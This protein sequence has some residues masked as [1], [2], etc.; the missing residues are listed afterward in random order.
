M[1]PRIGGEGR[2]PG[3]SAEIRSNQPKGPARS[4]VHRVARVEM[5]GVREAM[6]GAF[7]ANPGSGRKPGGIRGRFEREEKEA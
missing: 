3:G 5:W 2:K 1:V 7:S 6:E 4:G